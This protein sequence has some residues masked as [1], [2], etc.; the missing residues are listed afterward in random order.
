MENLRPLL[1]ESILK[2]LPEE[3]EELAT[4]LVDAVCNSLDE[5]GNTET[6]KDVIIAKV[7]G[8]LEGAESTLAD[9]EDRIR[10]A[11]HG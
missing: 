3:H 4:S 9:A 6:I 10:G 2:Q 8:I 11:K 1:K 7:S 5:G